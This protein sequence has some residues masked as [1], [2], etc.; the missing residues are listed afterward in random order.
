MKIHFY[1]TSGGGAQPEL[2]CSCRICNYAREHRGPDLRTRSQA[3]INNR[4]LV[5]FPVDTMM[6]AFYGGLDVRKYHHVIITHNHFDHISGIER[7]PHWR[8]AASLLHHLR[9]RHADPRADGK[10]AGT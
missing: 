1:G 3:L 6:H 9:F 5:E 4:L 2:Y 7:P 8:H 10:G